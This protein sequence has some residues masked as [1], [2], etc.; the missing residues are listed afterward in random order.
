MVYCEKSENYKL[1]NSVSRYQANVIQKPES[2]V[3]TN[4]CL[5]MRGLSDPWKV[6]VKKGKTYL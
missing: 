2:Q 1:T 5:I 6:E 4:N 3:G